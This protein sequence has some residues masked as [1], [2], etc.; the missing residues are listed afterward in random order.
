MSKMTPKQK[1]MYFRLSYDY[2]MDWKTKP[3]EE[4]FPLERL[5]CFVNV[6]SMMENRIRVYFWTASFYEQFASE[7][8]TKSDV[9]KTISRKKYERFTD[10][11]YP[12]NTPTNT[13]VNMIETLKTRHL[14]SNSEREELNSLIDIRNGITHQSMFN[15]NKITDEH[16][17]RIMS[18][19]RYI[20][21]KLKS[22]RRKYLRREK[23]LRGI[24]NG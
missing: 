20:D 23:E 11:P 21:R 2:W 8:D 3:D 24:K 22:R 10:D 13:L 18:C 17:D 5:G 15:L 1:E 16:I 6:F 9:W 7:L 19:F 4:K 12:P 14:I